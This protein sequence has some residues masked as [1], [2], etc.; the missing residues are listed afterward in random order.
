MKPPA[1]VEDRLRELLHERGRLALPH[2][3]TNEQLRRLTVRLPAERRRGAFTL[4]AAA[5]AVFV[6]VAVL[7]I[8]A[9]FVAG[10]R[11]GRFAPAGPTLPRPAPGLSVQPLPAGAVLAT[12]SHNFITASPDLVVNNVLW[13]DDIH[14]A[15][16]TRLDATTLA[17]LGTV[18]YLNHQSS[19]QGVLTSVAGVVVLAIDDTAYAGRAQILRFDA[20]TGRRLAPIEV[21]HAGSVVA[22]PTGAFAVVGKDTVGLLDAQHGKITRSFTMPVDHGLAY[23][24]GLLWGWDRPAHTL[25]GV[26]PGHGRAVRHYALP[27]FADVPL[28]ADGNGGLLLAAA[29]DTVRIEAATGRVAA[30]ATVTAAN[31]VP[32]G[33]GLIWG[34]VGGRRLVALDPATLAMRESYSVTNLDLLAISADGTKLYASSDA[35]GRVRLFDLNALRR[36]RR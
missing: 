15:T 16:V 18:H 13:V 26:E 30:R 10:D 21:A 33:A 12:T 11:T 31:W 3:Q 29:G 35:T 6:A 34:I 36:P 8:G 1:P 27:G 23:A 17:D 25:V 32:D 9:L 5:A 20:I 4:V 24:D 7:S 22:T 28:T 19:L 14:A 2:L